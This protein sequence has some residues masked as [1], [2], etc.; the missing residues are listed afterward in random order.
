MF[1]L[2]LRRSVDPE[3]IV[4]VEQRKD[5]TVTISSQV[6]HMDDICDCPYDVCYCVCLECEEESMRRLME[7]K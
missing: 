5:T 3:E 1:T 4:V 6:P 2:P 7:N